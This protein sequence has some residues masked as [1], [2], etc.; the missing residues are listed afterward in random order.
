M[1]TSN[2]GNI[3][4]FWNIGESALQFADVDVGKKIN[5]INYTV[6]FIQMTR[7]LPRLDLQNAFVIVCVH[8]KL[9]TQFALC[10]IN[11]K[12]YTNTVEQ[13]NDR[14]QFG[15]Q[16]NIGIGHWIFCA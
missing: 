15:K 11:H 6:V 16:L 7:L 4:T 2:I 1:C 14:V 10:Y 5:T 8:A 12:L 3:G 13:N 9:Q